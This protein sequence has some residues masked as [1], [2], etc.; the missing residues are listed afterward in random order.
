M[1]KIP[2]ESKRFKKN[3]RDSK[4]IKE[5]SKQSKRFQKNKKIQRNLKDEAN[6]LKKLISPPP[7]CL[8][9]NQKI[10]GALA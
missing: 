9:N 1:K 8:S 2:K 4:T 6:K 3:Q 5:I 7:P 10:R